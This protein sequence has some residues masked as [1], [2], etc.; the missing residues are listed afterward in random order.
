MS[1]HTL[2]DEQKRSPYIN[3]TP[4]ID[5]LLVMLIIF[6]V[7]TPQKPSRFKAMVPEPPDDRTLPPNPTT[8]VVTIDKDLRL[9]LNGLEEDFGT[10]NDTSK[11]NAALVKLFQERREAHLYRDDMATRPGLTED[12]RTLKTV[13]IKAPRS[14]SY[15]AVARVID[16]VKG[17]GADPLGLQIDDLN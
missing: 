8:L 14:I 11:L 12:E 17:A 9:R 15:G 3:V 1:G 13:F 16:G 7:V 4:L 10:V 5:V 2:K 6:M